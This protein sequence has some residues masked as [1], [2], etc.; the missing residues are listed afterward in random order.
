M[1]DMSRV[2]S[3]KENENAIVNSGKL[4]NAILMR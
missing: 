3:Q 1:T 2:A 4:P